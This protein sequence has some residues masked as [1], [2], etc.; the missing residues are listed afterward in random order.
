MGP[1]PSPRV[2]LYYMT[3]S[4]RGCSIKVSKKGAM[5]LGLNTGTYGAHDRGYNHLLGACIGEWS[6]VFMPCDLDF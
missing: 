3:T 4:L 5:I 6:Y 2:L 1:S